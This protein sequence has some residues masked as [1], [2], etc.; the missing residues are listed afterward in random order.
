MQ[1]WSSRWVSPRPTYCISFNIMGYMLGSFVVRHGMKRSHVRTMVQDAGKYNI[2]HDFSTNLADDG[3]LHRAL[4][5]MTFAVEVP[6]NNQLPTHSLMVSQDTSS[7]TFYGQLKIKNKKAHQLCNSFSVL[8]SRN[9]TTVIPERPSYAMLAI[10]CSEII[11]A[12]VCAY[13]RA[14][15]CDLNVAIIRK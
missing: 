2:Y 15:M 12:H 14:R 11:Y 6:Q 8:P 3:L 13:G 5:L 4:A 1:R 7:L 9:A 10:T